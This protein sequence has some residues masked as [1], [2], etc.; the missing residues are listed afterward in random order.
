MAWHRYDT[1]I[2]MNTIEHCSN[3]IAILDNIWQSL[4]PGGILVFAEEYANPHKLA[5]TSVCHPLRITKQFYMH[6]FQQL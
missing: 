2:M 5:T 3:A 6:F 4:K 1:A